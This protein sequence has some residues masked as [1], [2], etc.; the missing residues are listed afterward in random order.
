[1]RTWRAFNATGKY[2]AKFAV[3][4]FISGDAPG[5]NITVPS[6][7]EPKKEEARRLSKFVAYYGAHAIVNRPFLVSRRSDPTREYAA[8]VLLGFLAEDSVEA[9]KT[10]LHDE[11][12]LIIWGAGKA[13]FEDQYTHYRE[14]EFWVAARLADAIEGREL[15]PFCQM[16]ESGAVGRCFWLVSTQGVQ[17]LIAEHPTSPRSSESPQHRPDTNHDRRVALAHRLATDR[18]GLP[19][20]IHSRALMSSAPKRAVGWRGTGARRRRRPLE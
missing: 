17:R 16:F 9:A 15:A 3:Y 12:H 14:T 20:G 10:S 11:P 1:M 5:L 18:V 2:G 7:F 8:I 4:Q 6:A 13:T 19:N